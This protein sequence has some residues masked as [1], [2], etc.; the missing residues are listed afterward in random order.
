MPKIHLNL[1]K[2]DVFLL[3]GYCEIRSDTFCVEQLLRRHL[4]ANQLAASG[5]IAEVLDN[6]DLPVG[7]M[8]L[9]EKQPFVDVQLKAD[10]VGELQT[11]INNVPEHNRILTEVIGDEPEA[12]AELRQRTHRF[13]TLQCPANRELRFEVSVNTSHPEIARYPNTLEAEEHGITV[14]IDVLLYLQGQTGA[15]ARFDVPIRLEPAVAPPRYE[16]VVS[17]DLGN[18]SS[19]MVCMREAYLQNLAGGD[20]FELLFLDPEDQQQNPTVLSGIGVRELEV[21]DSWDAEYV[22]GN[23][24]IGKRIE[25]ALSGL[26]LGPK[27]MVV[28]PNRETLH[29]FTALNSE[30]VEIPKNAPAEMF[31]SRLL[32]TFIRHKKAVP[33][34]LHITY[35]TT[36]SLR[37][38]SV[39]RFA[40]YD[41]I[42]MALGQRKRLPL[43]TR[44]EQND[45]NKRIAHALPSPI[46][47]AS[48][49]ASYLLF[50]D[51]VLGPGAIKSFIEIFP[52]G[53]NVLVYDCGG[54]T[55]D[56]ALVKATGSRRYDEATQQ[57]VYAFNVKNVTRTG[58][59][60]FGGDEIT[61]AVY[62]LLKLK[63]ADK[64]VAVA[65]HE[66]VRF[67]PSLLK[68][69]EAREIQSID[70]RR[71]DWASKV[72]PTPW[73]R[74]G[75]EP[76]TTVREAIADI[77]TQEGIVLALWQIA[78]LIKRELAKRDVTEVKLNQSEPGIRW[79]GFALEFHDFLKQ[80]HPATGG[81]GEPSFADLDRDELTECWESITISRSEVN[82]LIHK[83]VMDTVKKMNH[84]IEHKLGKDAE[85]SQIYVVGNASRY[86]LV[87][88][89]IT[90]NV[91]VQFAEEKTTQEDA[92]S[93]L[94]VAKGACIR[95]WLSEHNQLVEWSSDEDLMTRLPHDVVLGGLGGGD[96]EVLYQE[97][98][99]YLDLTTQEI[100]VQVVTDGRETPKSITLYRRWP[101]ESD[102]TKFMQ[103]AF[104]RPLVG[105]V[106]VSFNVDKQIFEM[107]DNGAAAPR[108][109][110][111]VE[112]IE[113]DY[114]PH[115][116]SGLI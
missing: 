63:L 87:K 51:Y 92:D 106:A 58:H 75:T 116:Q 10:R 61:L 109:V 89:M 70:E 24:E 11:A 30:L 2:A 57:E 86:P 12:P 27:R 37:E 115:V 4:D 78:E 66:G 16:G 101:R 90:E 79:S 104:D 110:Q 6:P 103:F 33:T 71:Q 62:W 100:P 69:E 68:K 88:Q 77:G 95:A 56:I 65:V 23:F 7:L 97:G 38:T 29:E 1:K 55:T 26:I 81:P 85:I 60:K 74:P 48:A 3:T 91:K 13:V 52:R 22:Q 98:Q 73:A 82:N 107:Q 41:A 93:K 14:G 15:A 67:E 105:P 31:L 45:R 111:G 40:F 99:S 25:K 39:L 9:I 76:G 72:I 84:L 94:A 34:R 8:V 47:E 19:F 59:R 18:T 80:C 44:A 46:D 36:F 54:G 112:V 43:R 28:D 114:V 21:S 50:R 42:R 53:L 102:I 113:A 35:P 108:A 32:Q 17:I 83:D 5:S 49:A 20:P 64:T 96:P